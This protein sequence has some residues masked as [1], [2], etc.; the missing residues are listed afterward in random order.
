MVVRGIGLC[1][2]SSASRPAQAVATSG[3]MGRDA[4]PAV[5]RH[6]RATPWPARLP[7][8]PVFPGERRFARMRVSRH[9]AIQG[10]PS[11][12]LC[13]ATR[14][15]P[16]RF[17][18]SNRGIPESAKAK[19]PHES[20]AIIQRPRYLSR[21]GVALRAGWA[22]I[23]QSCCPISLLFTWRV[24]PSA[25]EAALLTYMPGVPRVFAPTV[26]CQKKNPSS[27]LKE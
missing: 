8:R 7:G 25:Y 19:T 5:W 20:P 1:V 21:M 15:M 4:H 22:Q 16:W 18:S 11:V 6:G 23:G 26:A 14:P 10:R 12:P 17:P 13:G 3:T 9:R 27:L 24:L 2:V